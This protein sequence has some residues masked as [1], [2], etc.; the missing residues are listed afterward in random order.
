[1][2]IVLAAASVW[3]AVLIGGFFWAL[4]LLDVRDWRCYAVSLTSAPVLEGVYWG[5]LTLLLLLPLAVAWRWRDRPHVA[6]AAIGVLV[7]A[8]LFA[9]PLVVWLLLTRRFVAAGWAVATSVVLVLASW[10]VIGFAGFAD[11]PALLGVLQDVYAVRSFSLSTIVGATGVPTTL[12][13]GA[14]ILVGVGLLCWAGSLVSRVDGDR[15]SYAVILAASV[16]ATPIVWPYY[17]AL[18]FVPIAIRWPRLALAWFFG[19]L[20]FLMEFLPAFSHS[21]AEPCCRPG[22]VPPLV[23]RISHVLPEPWR[24]LGIAFVLGVLVCLLVRRRS[25]DVATS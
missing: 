18:F 10:A 2:C 21:E 12:S 4:W 15:R 5:N 8:K 20:I 24:A 23:W 9:W 14:G 3:T 19:Q 17:F 11:Y 22:D 16:V 1:M 7:A 6:G 25:D 13:V